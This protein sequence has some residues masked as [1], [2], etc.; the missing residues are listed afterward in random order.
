MR[1]M[2]WCRDWSN[3]MGEGAT[4][5]TLGC[6]CGILGCTDGRK[7]GSLEIRFSSSM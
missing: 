4:S 2:D 3:T 5:G 7:L 6:S 1:L